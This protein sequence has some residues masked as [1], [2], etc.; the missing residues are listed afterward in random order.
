MSCFKAPS[1]PGSAGAPGAPGAPCMPCG[2]CMMPGMMP[3]MMG[4]TQKMPLR[5]APSA[6][7]IYKFR[8]FQILDGRPVM[9]LVILIYIYI[10]NVYCTS[11]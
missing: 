8:C 2:G 6:I 1:S 7:L 3:G 9:K 11:K 10:Y 5:C 4:G